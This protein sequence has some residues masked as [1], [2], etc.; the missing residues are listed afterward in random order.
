MCETLECKK[1]GDKYPPTL[2][3]F[4][5]DPRIP[6][7][8]RALCKPCKRKQNKDYNDA[9]Q[10]DRAQRRAAMQEQRKAL[11]AAKDNA[12]V[13]LLEDLPDTG[14]GYAAQLRQVRAMQDM[15]LVVNVETVTRVLGVPPRRAREIL[16]E[17][18][19]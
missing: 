4:V 13:C 15:N 9:Y 10:Q 7:G 18:G 2:E 16:Q 11:K 6:R 5:A 17:V 8:I 3:Y 12:D 1:C 19:G 14:N